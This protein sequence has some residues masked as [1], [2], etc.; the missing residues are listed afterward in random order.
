MWANQVGDESDAYENLLHYNEKSVSFTGPDFSKRYTNSTLD[1]DRTV[2]NN[3]L[4]GPLA[5]SYANYAAPTAS[6]FQLAMEKAGIPLAKMGFSS[7]TL[8]GNMWSTSTIY[9]NSA[10]RCS[11]HTSFLD[12]AVVTSTLKVFNGTMARRLLFKNHNVASGVLV[13]TN[14]EDY[15]LSARK[16]VILSAGAFQSPQLLMVSGVG[17]KDT[18]QEHDI[19][20]IAELSEVGQNMRDHVLF[21]ISNRVETITISRLVADPQYAA[22]AI[23]DYNFNQTGPLTGFGYLA[24]EKI[25]KQYRDRFS[26]ATE[27]ALNQFPADWPEMEYL[28]S[29][30]Y[31]GYNT[32]Y[33]TA[34]PQDGYQYA[35]IDGALVAPLSRG[36]VTIGSKDTMVSYVYSEQF[37][38][39][40]V[41]RATP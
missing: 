38:T 33:M 24:F 31:T 23:F 2:F 16:E 29:D 15:V 36:N 14:G 8:F 26:C 5:V 3:A 19:P 40:R 25:P 18:L 4:D 27:T 10:Q 6:W 1:Y 20:L 22:Q 32:N 41:I 7:G 35:S 28:L 17:P 21:S 11:S 37:T 13:T 30:A 39:T 34:D 9:P 12:Q